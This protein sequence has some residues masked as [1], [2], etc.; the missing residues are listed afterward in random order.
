MLKL[1]NKLMLIL[2][3]IILS[4]S[5]ITHFLHRVIH[6]FGMSMAQNNNNDIVLNLLLIAPIVTLVIAFSLYRNEH[7]HYLIP[8]SI[9]LT[10][11]F[12]SMSMISGGNG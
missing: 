8:W 11:T 12:S 6:I 7:E 5:V 10:L 4:I 2:S 9:M 3:L 1:K